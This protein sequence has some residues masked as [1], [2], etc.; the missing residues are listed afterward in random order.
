MNVEEAKK[1]AKD[2]EREILDRVTEFEMASGLVVL[3]VV[4]NRIKFQHLDETSH[5]VLSK[6]ELNV[7]LK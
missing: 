6:V 2:L 3:D 5:S 7:G 4:I 1:E